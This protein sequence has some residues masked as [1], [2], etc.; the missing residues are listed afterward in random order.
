MIRYILALVP[1]KHH[2]LAYIKT[3]Q[4]AFASLNDGYLLN[5][6]TSLPHVTI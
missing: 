2:A 3:A 6:D 4:Q 1:P 5:N